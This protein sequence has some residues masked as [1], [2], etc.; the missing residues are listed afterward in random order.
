MGLIP[1]WCLLY[2]IFIRAADSFTLH[3]LPR[4]SSSKPIWA[5]V[6]RARLA[7]LS[8]PGRWC[9]GD[10]N[11][12]ICVL[13]GKNNPT[14]L[15]PGEGEGEIKVS[16]WDVLQRLCPS[17]AQPHCSPWWDVKPS[18]STWHLEV[19]I[20]SLLPMAPDSH[21][22]FTEGWRLE[23]TS[24]SHLWSKTVYLH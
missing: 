12:I 5:G 21:H 19:M 3:Q 22:R 18:A 23:G 8:L 17:S 6:A 11:D 14:H 10:C 4:L 20:S 16:V 9:C 1:F 7:P 24:G 13:G 2:R 15:Q